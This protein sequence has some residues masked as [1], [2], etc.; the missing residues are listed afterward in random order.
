[1]TTR[2][3]QGDRDD[4]D[5]L[6]AEFA[7]GLLDPVE[8]DAVVARARADGALSLRI[9]WWRDQFAALAEDGEAP[10]E[11]LWRAIAARLPANDNVMQAMRRWRVAASGAMTVAAALLAFVAVRP[12]P[13]PI[14]VTRQAPAPMVAMLTGEGGRQVALT[15]SA[16]SGR[17]RIVPAALD[18]KA[19][20][21]ELW[22]IPADGKPR[23]MGVFG[24]KAMED[25]DVA[26][27][28]RALMAEGATFAVSLE[29]KGGSPKDGPTGPVVATGKMIRV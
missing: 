9:A 21:A 7:L 3:A 14:V 10:P 12:T 15:Y 5:L 6:A 11:R 19:G 22:V 26:P 25:H 4:D 18:A 8:A 28:M 13:H 17:M 2:Q 20:D 27:P 1:M 16:E 23:S 29:P 24:D